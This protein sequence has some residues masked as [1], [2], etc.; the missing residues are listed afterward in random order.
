[1]A[2]AASELKLIWDSRLLQDC[3]NQDSQQQ[4]SIVC[5]L[6][7][8]NIEQLED[9]SELELK[10]F[11]QT[12]DYRWRILRQRYLGVEPN[13]AYRRLMTRLS[14]LVGRHYPQQNPLMP[15]LNKQR[16]L[17]DLLETVI[18]EMI[19][20]D[21]W[22]KQKM[23]WI[24]QCSEDEHLRNA[25]WLTTIEEYCL[26]PIRN[27]PLIIDR[28]VS[29]LRRQV[30]EASMQTS[31]SEILLDLLKDLKPSVPE[32]PSSNCLKETQKWQEVQVK[33]LGLTQDFERYLTEKVGVLEGCWLRLYLQGKT[34]EAIA[35]LLNLPIKTVYKLQEQVQY[36]ALQLFSLKKASELVS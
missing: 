2:I 36:H 26:R 21:C 5:W 15:N 7:G 11:H 33:R 30:S 4:Q 19:Q 1:M 9:L 18:Q 8:E 29:L 16:K 17:V 28:L 10:I 13:E 12:L 34:Q 6:L 27:H 35:T 31:A 20:G 25:L 14:S 3:Q 24:R 23:T 22:L 32:T